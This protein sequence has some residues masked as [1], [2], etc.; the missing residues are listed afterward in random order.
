MGRS[1]ENNITSPAARSGASMTSPR[2]TRPTIRSLR[3]ERQRCGEYHRVRSE[4]W[5]LFRS[6]K[7]VKEKLD[8]RRGLIPSWRQR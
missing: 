2:M 7:A 1:E 5:A 8:T 6:F 4:S 3:A